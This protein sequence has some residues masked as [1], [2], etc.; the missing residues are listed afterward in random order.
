MMEKMEKRDLRKCQGGFTLIEI[1]A[2]LVI[3]GILAAVAVPKFIGL[4]DEARKKSLEGA[5]AAAQ[6]QISMEYARLILNH[7]SENDAWAN[8]DDDICDDVETSG[9]TSFNWENC[10]K[11]GNVYTIKANSDGQDA[12]GY[13]NRPE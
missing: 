7:G 10:S 2:V 4:Q 11:S 9:F 8:L 12:T 3:L 5:I 13:F 6:S 1:I